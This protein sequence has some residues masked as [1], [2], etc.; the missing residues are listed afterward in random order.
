V[1]TGP[2]RFVTDFRFSLLD[3][4][5]VRTQLGPILLPE[6][7]MLR[8][9]V[10]RYRQFGRFG[11]EGGLHKF[12]I[13]ARIFPD[14]GEQRGFNPDAVPSVNLA[15]ALTYD[16]PIWDR[17]A[18]HASLRVQQ[19]VE[20]SI[21]GIT[22]L[23]LTNPLDQFSGQLAVQGS[24]DVTKT[25]GMTLG[26]AYGQAIANKVVD[27]IVQRG[28]DG[29]L[30]WNE[31]AL[32]IVNVERARRTKDPLTVLDTRGQCGESKTRTLWIDFAELNRPGFSTLVDREQNCS[33]SFMGALT[34]GRT[35]AFD[36]DLFGNVRVWP[37]IGGLFG[38]GIRW[39][40][41]P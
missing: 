36:V 17:F 3:W 2:T 40:I 9:S 28:V 8:L 39:R 21:Q 20:Q 30:P 26:V 12:D 24:W 41:A 33:L 29:T 1:G 31:Q 16:V 22:K 5:E 7:L 13:G 38:A 18:L 23:D 4:L 27:G 15:G 34:Y 25:L 35:E 32:P 6:S 19:R 37:T 11:V 14:A 10:G